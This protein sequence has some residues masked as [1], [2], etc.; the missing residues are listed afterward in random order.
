MVPIRKE[1]S[2]PGWGDGGGGWSSTPPSPR[3]RSSLWENMKVYKRKYRFG[4]FSV[5]NFSDFWVPVPPPRALG[6]LCLGQQQDMTA[7]TTG[8][9]HFKGVTPRVRATP[10]WGG[11]K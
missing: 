5:I 6:E 4:L 9:T 11:A 2:W 3:T 10:F 1:E 7:V 8:H